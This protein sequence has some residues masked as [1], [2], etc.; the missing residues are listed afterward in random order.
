MTLEKNIYN[1]FFETVRA[2]FSINDVS[3]RIRIW[4]CTVLVAVRNEL[5][6][7]R[8][9][10]RILWRVIFLLLYYVLIS[11]TLPSTVVKSMQ[12]IVSVRK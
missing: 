8:I 12:Y 10:L 3:E 7:S 1:A 5:S 6:R 9:R 11:F 4:R 2:R